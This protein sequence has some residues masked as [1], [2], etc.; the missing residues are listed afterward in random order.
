MLV[1]TH[2]HGSGLIE[3]CVF[4]CREGMSVYISKHVFVR[5]RVCAKVCVCVN[6]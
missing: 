2:A 3:A 5:I 1:Y 4:S 6:V